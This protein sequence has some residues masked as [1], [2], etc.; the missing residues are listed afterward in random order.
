MDVSTTIV[1]SI[2]ELWAS[3]R[4]QDLGNETDPL[5]GK[6]NQ[7][8]SHYASED[9]IHA[10]LVPKAKGLKEQHPLLYHLLCIVARFRQSSI[11]YTGKPSQGRFAHFGPTVEFRTTG[12]FD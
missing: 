10:E 12:L 1:E 11:F 3:R 5:T 7:N 8:D 4:R 6:E 2:N 9:E